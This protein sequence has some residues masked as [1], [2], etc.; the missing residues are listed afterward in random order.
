M[1]PEIVML[2]AA[3]Q[4]S[5]A[6]VCW[7][8][9]RDI[10]AEQDEQLM[11]ETGDIH[12]AQSST[13][14]MVSISGDAAPSAGTEA[15][16]IQ[17][18]EMSRP[19]MQRSET[20]EQRQQRTDDERWTLRHA[21]FANM[22]GFR[23]KEQGN[24]K[25]YIVNA[26][27]INHLVRKGYIDLPT[28]TTLEIN[29]RSKSDSLAKF[30]AIMQCGWLAVQ[31]VAR[32]IQKLETTSLEIT[33]LSFVL[34]TMGS[35]IAWYRKPYDV[36]TFTLLEMKN[37][38]SVSDIDLTFLDKGRN[39]DLLEEYQ[40]TH[41][42]AHV[43]DASGQLLP[44]YTKLDII[45][46]GEPT[47]TTNFTDRYRHL[48]GSKPRD[49]NRI[50]NDRLPMLEVRITLVAGLVT[51]GYAGLHAAAWNIPLATHIEQLLWRVSSVVMLGCCV[52]WFGMDHIQGYKIRRRQRREGIDDYDA[53]IPWW[54]VPAS[55]AVAIAYGLCRVYVL[56]ESFLALR[57]MPISTYQQVDWGK[58]VPH[59]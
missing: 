20:F 52:A 14:P 45:D 36:Q 29:D 54:R 53:L 23:L 22:G 34:C 48:W 30:L 17:M 40:A 31:V 33:T 10:L 16:E 24:P 43:V 9:T 35:F 44:P 47:F 19:K 46:D 59:I 27:H 4:W 18:I 21:F 42:N 7:R 28:I 1:V 55:I 11:M 50:R 26:K 8:E 56:I 41:P 25:P 12:L 3:G 37:H 58:W 5:F 13:A 2:L 6:R 57:W 32:A 15:E 51:F 38:Y 49:P 39:R